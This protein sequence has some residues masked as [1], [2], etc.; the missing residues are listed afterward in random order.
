MS[1]FRPLLGAVARG[2]TLAPQAMEEAVSLILDGA[3]DDAEIAAF[4]GALSA[5]GETADE[6]AAAARVMRRR[7]VHVAAPDG[8]ID[9]CGVGGDGF[10]TRNVS[11]AAAFV[12]AGAGAIVAKHGNRAASSQS[13]SSDVLSALGLPIDITLEKSAAALQTIGCAFFFAPRHHPAL[14]RLAPLR[15]TLGFR[16]LF[17]LLGPL[18]NPCAPA[19]QVVGAPTERQARL[20]ADALHK[21]GTERAM[22]VHGAEGLDEL[23][24]SGPS[25]ILDVTAERIT[26]RR[27][28]P[29]DAGL[30]MSPI[31]AI[32]GGDPSDNAAAMRRLF[33]GERSAYRD[34]VV[35]NAAAALMVA[36]RANAWKDGARHAEAAIDSGAAKRKL[37]DLASF[38]GDAT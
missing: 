18:A 29:D 14:T 34:I 38:L 12:A 19:R 26:A 7:M 11:T 16:T 37:A 30:T 20:F 17:N 9:T 36:G 2:E 22:V 27:V 25:L 15:K 28:A 5:R 32:K 3:A 4:L 10:N 23:S 8:V 13:G 6:L 1:A 24:I 31:S 33:D 21:L 35:L